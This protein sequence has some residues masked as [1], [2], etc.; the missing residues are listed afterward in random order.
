MCSLFYWGWPLGLV[1]MMHR[2]CST[3][4]A[5]WQELALADFDRVMAVNVRGMFLVTRA[6]LPLMYEQN[7][8]RIVLTAS[9]TVSCVGGT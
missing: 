3:L 6:V 7:Y 5:V 8:G 2:Q 1:M 4:L 9:Q